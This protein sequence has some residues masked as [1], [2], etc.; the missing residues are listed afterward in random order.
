M[1]IKLILGFE[2]DIMTSIDSNNED[3][4]FYKD[5]V[6]FDISS[7]YIIKDKHKDFFKHV[8]FNHFIDFNDV[9][10][11]LTCEAGV[12]LNEILRLIV[13]KGWFLAVT[14]GTSFVTIGGAIASD[15][16]GK[17]HHINGTFSEYVYSFELLLGNGEIVELTPKSWTV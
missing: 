1:N 9:T 15:V 13:P 5:Y 8:N 16:H 12:S 4:V 11:V 3:L 2:V 10:G 17:N 6:I 7:L 14:P